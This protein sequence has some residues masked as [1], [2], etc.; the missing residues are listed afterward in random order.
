MRCEMNSWPHAV[1]ALLSVCWGCSRKPAPRTSV[2]QER[3][4]AIAA[5]AGDAAVPRVPTLP[6]SVVREAPVRP[7]CVGIPANGRFR[8]LP[9]GLYFRPGY[10]SHVRKASWLSPTWAAVAGVF[11]TAEEAQ[12]AVRSVPMAS[13]SPG[14]PWVVGAKSLGLADPSRDGFVV[15]LG[16]FA[17]LR[18]AN[19]WCAQE[20]ANRASS[21]LLELSSDEVWQAHLSEERH[22]S[23]QTVSWAAAPAYS[24]EVVERFTE[25]RRTTVELGRVPYQMQRVTAGWRPVCHIAPD[26]V[27]ASG[28]SCG[29]TGRDFV[30]AD[31]DGTPACI[32]MMD[33]FIWSVIEA[34]SR[35][36]F[37]VSQVVGV[38]CDTPTFMVRNYRN[39]QLVSE[40]VIEHPP[41]C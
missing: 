13:R 22:W 18:D 29:R 1:L 6:A 2:A 8:V 20:P 17:A 15:V 9:S 26:T 30:R 5:P 41:D 21:Q 39:D 31:C 11:A 25:H 4:S 23:T 12:A 36:T 10:E 40:T 3:V 14:Y 38:D 33:T 7:T 24:L 32:R 35:G 16:L 19:G 37:R 27:L 34:R 28:A